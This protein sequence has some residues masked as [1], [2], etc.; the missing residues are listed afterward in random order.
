MIQSEVTLGFVYAVKVSGKVAPVRLE[1]VIR[2][3]S[4]LGRK[5]AYGGTNLSTNRAVHVRSAAKLRFEL[6]MCAA[7]A[8]WIRR[9]P[10]STLCRDC[11]LGPMGK[12]VTL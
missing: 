9:T 4:R 8:R 11:A 12:R 10:G 5:T 2:K 7:C 1:S 3:D 6:T